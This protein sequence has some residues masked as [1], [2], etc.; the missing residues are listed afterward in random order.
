LKI[1]IAFEGKNYLAFV[2]LV[3]GACVSEY[4]VS[5]KLTAAVEK[6]INVVKNRR[7]F[8][9]VTFLYSLFF[10]G[11][12]FVKF[13]QGGL[14]KIFPAI[15]LAGLALLELLLWGQCFAYKREKMIQKGIEKGKFPKA[16]YALAMSVLSAIVAVAVMVLF[17]FWIF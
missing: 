3:N 15:V 7:S 6:T 1:T 11:L 10:A 5:E 12:G 16:K 13:F 2:N 17:V 4:P 8:I 9:F 14:E